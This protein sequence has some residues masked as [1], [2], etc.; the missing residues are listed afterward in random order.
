M[1]HH[2]SCNKTLRQKNNEITAHKQES[3]HTSTTI[4]VNLPVFVCVCVRVCACVNNGVNHSIVKCAPVVLQ[5]LSHKSI[6]D[7]TLVSITDSL[8]FW[9]KTKFSLS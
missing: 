9:C 7:T 3:N 8:C 2:A 6:C 4:D 1:L 5:N